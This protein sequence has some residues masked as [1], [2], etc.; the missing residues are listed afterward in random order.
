MYLVVSPGGTLRGE[1]TIPGDKSISHRALI[2]GALAQGPTIIEGFLASEDCLATLNI[3]QLLGVNITWQN[4]QLIV[5]GQGLDAL[6]EPLDVLDCGNSGTSMRLLAGLLSA[7]PFASTLVGDQSLSKRPMARVVSPLSQMGAKI[8]GHVAPLIIKPCDGLQAIRYEMPVASAQVKSCL[9]LA[10]LYANGETIITEKVA[11]RDHTERLLRYL[12]A[13]ITTQK[14]Q[15]RLNPQAILNGKA[16][17]IPAD[18]SSAAFFIAGASA[19][20]GAHILLKGIGI[21]PTRMGLIHILQAMGAE[22]TLHEKRYAG[23]E[24]IA[25]IEVKGITLQGIEVP[26]KW[27]VSAIDEFPVLFIAAAFAQGETRFSGLAE[28]RHKETDRIAMMAAGMEKLGVTLAI[29]PDGIIIRGSK[30]TGGIV[31][32]GGDHRI[33]MAFAIAA[34]Q[35]SEPITVQHAQHIATSFP[36]FCDIANLLGLSMIQEDNHE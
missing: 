10:G 13:D 1:T 11:S 34:L 16:L 29:L 28:L 30:I 35:A 3:L 25:D 18:I 17:S 26:E 7:Q 12:G 19:T 27:V 2:L 15:I 36:S 31:D 5:N 32:S 6:R 20:P 9:L 21:N 33:A 14:N 8:V 24:P 23:F 4:T 22:I